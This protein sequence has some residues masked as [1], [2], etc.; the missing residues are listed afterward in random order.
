MFSWLA[1]I[2]VLGGRQSDPPPIAWSTLIGAVVG[3]ALSIL[4]TLL[5]EHRR[6]KAA[7]KEA[8]RLQ[9]IEGRLA[10]RLIVAELQD[11]R[12]VLRVALERTPYAWPPS[13]SFQFEMGAWTAHG[14]ALAAAVPDEQWELV[15]GPYFSYRYANL[16][17]Q[18]SKPTAETMLAATEEAVHSLNEW[19]EA[20]S[21]ST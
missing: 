6:G 1:I 12:S 5:V 15:A 20:V 2:V 18:V 13:D 21:E 19:I 14:A 7:T 10:A 11:A 17:H 9:R 16:L 8:I 4:G 3:G